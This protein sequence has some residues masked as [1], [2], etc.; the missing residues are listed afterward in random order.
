LNP[1]GASSNVEKDESHDKR[2][3][4]KSNRDPI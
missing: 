3:R 2:E 4:K 1:P